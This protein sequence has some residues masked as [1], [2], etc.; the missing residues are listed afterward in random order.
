MELPP[1]DEGM[2]VLLGISHTGYIA[3]KAVSHSKDEDKDKGKNM[4]K[5]KGLMVP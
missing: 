3:N 2:N 1:I 4:D 5:C